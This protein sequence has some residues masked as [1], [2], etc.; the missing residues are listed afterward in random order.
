[1]IERAAWWF[2][3]LSIAFAGLALLALWLMRLFQPT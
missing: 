3:A 1:V 2:A